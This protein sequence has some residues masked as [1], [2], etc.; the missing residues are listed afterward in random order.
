M[1][2]LTDGQQVVR[3]TAAVVR[4][5]GERSLIVTLE[6]TRL[7]LRAKG[8]RRGEVVVDLAE[9]YE[10]AAVRQFGL[11][12]CPDPQRRIGVRAVG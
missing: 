10:G 5:G 4:D 6:P 11:R 9:L 8:T 7:R 1:T 3:E 2:R 12:A